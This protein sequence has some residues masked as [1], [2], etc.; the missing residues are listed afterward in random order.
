V[1]TVTTALYGPGDEFAFVMVK[2]G[3]D[4]GLES[5]LRSAGVALGVGASGFGGGGVGG[6]VGR[7]RLTVS[8]P[9]LKAPMVSAHETK[10][11]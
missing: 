7:C 11:S 4:A 8:K 9:V 10:I 5:E 3:C 1:F 6:M 2:A